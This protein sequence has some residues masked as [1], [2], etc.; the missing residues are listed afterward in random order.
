[1]KRHWKHWAGL[2]LLVVANLGAS[3]AQARTLVAAEIHPPGHVIVKSEELLASRLSELT[4]GELTVDLKHSAQL[5]NEDK[6]WQ[7][8]REG[9]LDIARVNLAALV[10]DVPA[11]KLLS[12][13]YLFRS[14][15]H[16]W[17]VLGGDF[18]KRLNAEAEKNGAVVLTYYDSGTRSFYT[19]KKPICARSDF[20]GLRIRVQNSPVWL[21]IR[22]R[23]SAARRSSSDTTKS[24]THSRPG[25]LTGPKTIRLPTYRVTITS[26][27][28]TTVWT[29]IRRFPKCC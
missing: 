4:K 14:R 19:T 27:P 22:S 17:R 20:A 3:S 24:S 1:M 25:R 6:S 23:F 15:E 18:G 7:G 26:T 8:V 5:G 28:A 29:S 10:N 21:R 11:A 16:M 12:L 9:A 13:P 2:S